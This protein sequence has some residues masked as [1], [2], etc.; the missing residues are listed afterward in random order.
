MITHPRMFAAPFADA[1]ADHITFHIES[2]G[3]PWDTIAHI[4]SLGCSVGMTVKPATPITALEPF[5]PELD[6]VLVMTV[7]PG[8]GGQSFMPAMMPKVAWLRRRIA[9]LGLDFHIE[10]DGGI[11]P[12]ATVEAAAANGA[13]VMVAGTAVFRAADPAAA[14][15]AIKAPLVWSGV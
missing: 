13:N 15:A 3:D 5:L 1:G 8:F 7:E 6:M 12:G 11:A 9:A 4:K 10:V 14:I 2:D